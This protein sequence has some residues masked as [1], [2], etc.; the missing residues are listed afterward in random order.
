M[1]LLEKLESQIKEHPRRI[2]F[3][4]GEDPRVMRAARK[5]SSGGFGVPILIGDSHKIKVTALN[6]NIG[7]EQIG[8]IDPKTSKDAAH[9]EEKMHAHPNF[10]STTKEKVTE[11]LED[12]NYFGAM[13]LECGHAEA[14]LSGASVKARMAYRALLE[15]LSRNDSSQ[16]ISSFSILDTRKS[17]IG[18][19]GLLFLTDTLLHPDPCAQTLARTAVSSARICQHLLLAPPRIALLGHT[20]HD[21]HSEDP[22]TSKMQYAAKL[23]KELAEEIS[24]ACEVAGEIQGDVALDSTIARLKLRHEMLGGNANVLVFPNLDAANITVKMLQVLSEVRT[25]GQI[26][27]GFNRAAGCISRSMQSTDIYGTAILLAYMSL[28]T[29]LLEPLSSDWETEEAG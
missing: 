20:N 21:P 12:P 9:F 14:L 18:S 17:S 24:L 2:V 7:L 25:Y 15:L 3:T 5:Y 29:Q 26:L 23:A 13:M 16:D 10:K 6:L 11:L 27:Q 22:S 8:I 28:N 19:N 4:D 1:F